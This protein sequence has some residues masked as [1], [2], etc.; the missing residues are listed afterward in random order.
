M[1]R[2]LHA[3]RNTW[4][5]LLAAARSEAA[6]R[7]ELILLVIALPLAFIVAA[8][9]WRRLALIAVVLL[10]LVVELLNTALEKLADEVT[11]EH[12][13][14]IGRIKDMASAAVGLSLLLAGLVW[15]AALG[16]RLGLL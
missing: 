8:E 6:F 7:Q 1:L 11:R 16:E 14:G 3:A 10:V 2:L 9:T 15:L 5:G 12:H 13:P 4:N